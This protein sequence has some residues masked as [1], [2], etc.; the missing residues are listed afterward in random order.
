M[1]RTIFGGVATLALLCGSPVLAQDSNDTSVQDAQAELDVVGTMFGDIFGA[2][3][4]LSPEEEARVPMAKSVVLKLFPEGT[5]AKMM[6]ETMKPMMEGMMGSIASSP[7]LMLLELT[8]MSP[9]QLEQV[10]D[11]NLQQAL[12][13]LDPSSA[14]RNAEIADVTLSLISDVMEKVEPSYRA[15]L[16][17]AYA[18]RFTQEELADLNAYF[19]TSVGKKYAA[20][21]FLI[22]SDPQV[23]ASMNDMVPAMMEMMPAM[24]GTITQITEKYP[25]GRTFSALSPEE[26]DQ[27]AI[28]LGTTLEDLAA[29]EP[30]GEATSDDD[31]EAEWVVEEAA[32]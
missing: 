14:E 8:G 3:N 20:E 22:Y 27:L 9:A 17:R 16:T 4:P 26:Q 30:V 23:M 28:L 7:S 11:A 31:A 10:D 18:V 19:A 1:K 13:I 6:N 5:Y 21:S 24:M 25:S 15:G 2:A 29:N 32:S 12:S